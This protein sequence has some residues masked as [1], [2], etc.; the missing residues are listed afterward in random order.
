MSKD[1]AYVVD[2]VEVALVR[3][4]PGGRFSYHRI[5]WAVTVAGIQRGWV[6][7]PAGVKRDHE[8]WTLRKPPHRGAVPDNRTL[9]AKS[10]RHDGD[11]QRRDLAERFAAG[12]AKGLVPSQAEL[13]AAVQAEEEARAADKRKY[14]A[15][16]AA[17]VQEG[18]DVVETLAALR[19]RLSGLLT[20]AE[21][22]ALETA[23]SK[24]SGAY[25]AGV[26]EEVA[27]RAAERDAEASASPTPG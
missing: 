15:S 26:R 20:N 11:A 12:V 14:E 23:A 7:L 22:A 8:A 13:D 10:Y 5:L 3:Q 27:R 18:A 24:L 4:P 9:L 16:R 21:V 25:P 6:V 19:D 2:G 1:E 17:S